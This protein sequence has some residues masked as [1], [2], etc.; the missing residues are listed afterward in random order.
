MSSRTWR[1]LFASVTAIAMLGMVASRAVA[2]PL[3]TV[4]NLGNGDWTLLNNSGQ[5]AG[6]GYTTYHSL[7]TSTEV[8]H[9]DTGRVSVIGVTPP[10]SSGPGS[11]NFRRPG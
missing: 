11:Y 6:G 10:S 5:V 8:Y 4:T 7:G 1:R 3:Y 2:D 9:G